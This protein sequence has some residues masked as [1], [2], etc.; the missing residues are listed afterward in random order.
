MTTAEPRTRVVGLVLAAGRGRRFAPGV[1]QLAPLRGHPLVTWAVTVARASTSVDRVVVVVGHEADTVTAAIASTFPDPGAVEVVAN[2]DHASGQAS[3]LALGVEVAAA[4]ADAQVVV[5]L[6]GDQPG[7][8]PGAVDAVVAA[9]DATGAD[10]ARARYEDGPGHPVAFARRTWD[11]LR[12]LEGDHGAREL[13]AGLRTAHVPRSGPVPTDVDS[14]DDL[15]VVAA[16]FVPPGA[17]VP[18]PGGAG[19]TGGA[20]PADGAGGGRR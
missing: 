19:G 12:S 13:L 14:P 17:G 1:K 7:V 5:V 18:G 20:D 11:R 3:S 4:D 10:A 16:G 6:L 2:P 9:L 8:D 15:A